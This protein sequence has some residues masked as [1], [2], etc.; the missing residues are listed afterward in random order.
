MIKI[1]DS[2]NRRAVDALLSPERI[3]DEAT[4]RRVAQIV[5]DVRRNGDKALTRYARELDGLSGSI[6]VSID[7]MRRASRDVP[8][9]VRAAIR[10]AARNIRT[11]ARRQVPRGWRAR[12]AP[13]VT[14][15]Q[16]VVPL[17]RVGCYV[18][19]GRYPLPSSLLMTAIPADAAG[20]TEI[21]AVCPRPAPVVM[22][23]ALEAGVSRM[24]RVGGAHAVA[25][26]AYGTR[27]VP[28][29]DKIVGPGNRYVAAAKAL[30][31]ADCGIDFYAGPTEIVIVAARGSAEW[32]AADLIAQAEHDPDARAVLITPSRTLADRVAAQVASQMPS[33][34]PAR[35]AM[36]SHGGIIVTKSVD[37]AVSLANAAAPEHLVVDD[38]RMAR[39]VRCAGSL[40][41]GPWSA[42]VAGDYAI[43]S[44]HVLPTAG[45][46]R[47]RGGLSAADFVRQITVQRL[48]ASGLNR[49]GRAV[50]DLANAE[51]L[52]AHAASV[53]I[54]MKE[55]QR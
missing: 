1:V 53:A 46:A 28:R 38:D 23:A 27:T 17:D 8:A 30:V 29:V 10:T 21:V 55:R 40:F 5:A 4:E 50:V 47:V 48:T 7:E 12:V 24:F 33:I 14:V 32:I 42:Q 43:G 13:G 34:G 31:A 15:E 51:G 54:R 44:N 25:A 9:P 41:V 22:A 3:R 11:V 20:V 45:T 2:K 26:L 18:P 19:A 39:R 36:K 35:S 6:E 37:E 52:A 49:I 16:R